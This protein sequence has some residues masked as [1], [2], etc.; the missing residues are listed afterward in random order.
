M[1]IG[2]IIHNPIQMLKIL[3]MSLNRTLR[4][5]YSVSGTQICFTSSLARPSRFEEPVFSN[6]H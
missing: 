6:M 2:K 4:A 1:G 3:E 5:S